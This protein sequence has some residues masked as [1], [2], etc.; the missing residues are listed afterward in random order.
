[1]F[2]YNNTLGGTWVSIPYNDTARPQSD[3][4][5][6]NQRWDYSKNRIYGV[7]LGGWLVL[8]PFITPYLFEPF[9]R[10]QP[11]PIDEWSLS[12]SMGKDYARRIEVHYQEFIHEEDFAQIA[13]AG[14]NWVRLPIG[15]W[16]IE[17]MGDEPFIAGLSWKFVLKAFGWARKYGLRVNLDLHAVPGSQVSQILFLGLPSTKTTQ[18]RRGGEKGGKC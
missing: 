4:P 7:N 11:V 9:L 18:K 16:V 6:L 10:S 15:W 3:Q 17:T 8:E 5:A 12:Q 2:V 1:M 13:A 14:L